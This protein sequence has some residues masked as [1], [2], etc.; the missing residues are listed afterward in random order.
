MQR[1]NPYRVSSQSTLFFKIFIPVFWVVFFT[2]FTLL[3]VIFLRESADLFGKKWYPITALFFLVCGTTVLY[4]TLW[5]LKRVEFG[6]EGFYVSN[7]FKTYRY[8][9][10]SISTIKEAD[11]LIFIVV[12]LSLFKKGKMGSKISFIASRKR[13]NSFLAE[14]KAI[15]ERFTK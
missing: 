14:N 5:K 8:T 11:W 3:S 10:D 7:Y 13:Y 2:G 4:F 1:T 15:F 12:S 9:Y 6:K